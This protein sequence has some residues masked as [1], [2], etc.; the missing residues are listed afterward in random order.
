VRFMV[1]RV[2]V[3]QVFLQRFQ[4][5]R[6]LVAGLSPPR[7]GFDPR[8]VYVRFMVEVFHVSILPPIL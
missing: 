1:D 3:E 7:P 8:S 5:L 2:A 6:W 4:C